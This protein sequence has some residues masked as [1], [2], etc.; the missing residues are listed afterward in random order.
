[1]ADYEGDISDCIPVLVSANFPC[2]KLRSFWDGKDA[3]DELI[4]L[5]CTGEM[6]DEACVLVLKNG[7]VKAISA[8]K[9]TL[10]SIYPEPFNTCTNGYNR[11]LRYIT[12][13]GVV[14]A[15]G[16]VK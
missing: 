8:E 12:P 13:V 16:T 15:D 5:L 4:E 3:A 1:M 9:L 10:S 2:D 6:K 11:Q 7:M 14:N